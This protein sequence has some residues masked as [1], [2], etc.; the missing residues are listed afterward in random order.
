M[1]PFLIG[2]VILGGV[3]SQSLMD[4]ALFL[5][6]FHFIKDLFQKKTQFKNFKLIGIEWA[7]IGYFLTAVISL[8]INGKPPVPW[9]FYLSKFNWIIN[10]YLLIYA[11]NRVEF[12]PKKWLKYFSI[13][14]VLPNI[15][16]LVTYFKEYDFLL[17]REIKVIVGLVD[18]ATYHAHGNSLIFIFFFALFLALYR[19]LSSHEKTLHSS[20]LIL[21]GLSTFLTFTRGIWGATFVS[22]LLL[23]FLLSRKLAASFLVLCTAGVTS[24][25]YLSSAFQQRLMN[26]FVSR[27]D[28]LRSQLLKVHWQMFSEHPWLGIGFWESYRQIADYWPKIGLARDYYESHAHNQVINVLATTGIIGTFFFI[29]IAGYF[30]REAFKFYQNSKNTYLRPLAIALLLLLIQ[31]GLACLTDVTF[32]YA[33]IRGLLIV[34]LAALISFKKRTIGRV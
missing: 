6:F 23:S 28:Q 26:S 4:S 13:A 12:E 16:A 29:A 33:K 34:G 31:F 9:F 22:M 3:T 1:L 32:E 19:S 30:L 27:S 10:L 14:F 15:Y 11:F 2:L 5:I 25:F 24:L 17:K 21:M 8:Y 7:F 18:S 20:M